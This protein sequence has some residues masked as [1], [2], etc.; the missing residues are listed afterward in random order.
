MRKLF[1]LSAVLLGFAGTLR[2]QTSVIT[3]PAAA[4]IVGVAPFFS[5]VRAF[6]TSYTSSLDVTATYRCFLGAC[7]PAPTEQAFTLLPRESRA[8][9]DMVA[10][11]SALNAPNSAGGVEFSFTGTSEQLV[12]TSRLFSTSPTPTVGMFIPGLP[13]SEAYALTVLTSVRNAGDG[14]GFRTNVGVFNPGNATVAVTFQILDNGVPVGNPVAIPGGVAAH[15]G[16]QVNAIF[17]AAGIATLSTVNAV[18]VAT[19]SAPIFSYAAVIDNNTSDPYLVIGAEDQSVTPV[20]TAT[21]TATPTMTPTLSGPTATRTPTAPGPTDTP[22]PPGP[23]PTPTPPPGGTQLV[24][25][26]SQGGTQF[27][28]SISGTSTSTIPAGTT[29]QWLWDTGFHSTTSG[30]C[31][32]CTGDGLWDSGQGSGMTFSHTF[33]VAGTFPYFCSVHG[34]SMTGM[35]IVN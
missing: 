18:I 2:A 19:A 1:L 29:I 20:V 21:P 27:I 13:N 30:P 11:P 5:D 4:S 16:A 35:V 6:N 7:P 28:D 17:N 10:S 3:V 9:N 8:F 34:T 15:A 12:V 22:T 32:P 14:R 33:G 26:T 31:P 25:V 24:A 23:T